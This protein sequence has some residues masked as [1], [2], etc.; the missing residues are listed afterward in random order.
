MPEPFDM[1]DFSKKLTS[2]LYRFDCPTPYDLG[3]YGLGLLAGDEKKAVEKHVSACPLCR[4]E[5]A[6]QKEFLASDADRER[7]DARELERPRQI[8]PFPRNEVRYV[9]VEPEAA[10]R[11][12]QAGETSRRVSITFGSGKFVELYY[13]IRRERTSYRVSGQ[14][15]ADESV[16]K[17]LSGA[18]IELW[19]D[20]SIVAVSTVDD[21]CSFAHTV[22]KLA[23]VLVRVSDVQGVFLSFNIDLGK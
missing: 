3:E 23:V 10:V 18:S 1:K 9:A 6:V 16:E 8:I 14:F 2:R 12:A 22:E 11:G 5:L 20:G 21:L 4:K 19:M 13:G 17:R 15:V 7:I